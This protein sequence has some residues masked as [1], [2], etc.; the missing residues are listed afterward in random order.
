MHTDRRTHTQYRIKPKVSIAHTAIIPHTTTHTAT[1][2]A[3]HTATPTTHTIFTTV[4]IT[5]MIG[6][7]VM[8]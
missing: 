8:Y 7:T 6:I 1:P 2:T 4:R 3:T 5:E